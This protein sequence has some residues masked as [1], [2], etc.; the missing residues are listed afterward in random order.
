[1]KLGFLT[2]YSEERVKFARANGFTCLELQTGPGAALDM[3]ASDDDLKKVKDTL[4]ENEISVSAVAYHTNHL[5]AGHEAERAEYLKRVIETAPK[6]GCNVVATMS[7]ITAESKKSGDVSKSIGAFK[8]TF[9]E[10][11][12]VAEASGV[13]IAFENW[14][15][16][17]PAP[18]AINIAVSPAAWQMMFDAVP[19]AALGLEYDPSHLERLQID[20][21]APIARFASRI[22]HVHA[23]DT[24]IRKDVL[25]EV[26]Y[27][28][29]GWWDYSIPGRG[30]VDWAAFFAALNKANYNG[31]VAIE[32][33]DMEFWN[34]KFDEGLILGQ[35]FL[36]QFVK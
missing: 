9:S 15:G 25:N 1:M 35:K 29:Q 14:P 17:H 6:I 22:H 8:Q 3:M 24:T 4:D 23:K 7:G 27:I 16:D 5:E 31:G 36:S 33:E 19:S 20:P 13:K 12:R 30:V 28:G 18:M 34:D 11:A 10:H 21:I 26:G 2:H 32:H